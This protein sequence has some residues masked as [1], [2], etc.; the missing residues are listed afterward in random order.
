MSNVAFLF[1]GQGSQYVG[2]G[3]QLA[4]TW[5]SAIQIFEQADKALGI[6]LSS[7]C[8]EGPEDKL[9]LT[10][11]TQPAILATSIAALELLKQKGVKTQLV[12]GHSLG[13]YTA[14]VAAGALEFQEALRL[15][16]RRGRYM[17]EAVEP[18]KGSMAAILGLSRHQVEAV[19]REAR[20]TGIVDLANINGPAQIVIAGEKNAVEFAGQLALNQGAK[21]VIPL[22]VSVPSHCELM[23]PAAR[24]LASDLANIR[25]NKLEVPLVANYHA[26]PVTKSGEVREA[27]TQQLEHPVLWVDSMLEMKSRGVDTF[28]EIGPGKVL[29]G[30]HKRIDRGATML[31]VDDPRSFEVTLQ[32]LKIRN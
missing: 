11:N 16:K 5:E 28:I 21:K 20:A 31:N 22:P 10:E 4:E 1:P 30:L 27:L 18:G 2:M 14:L 13:E 12:A 32:C 9:N 7:L 19:C 6:N 25:F 3:R 24:R 26:K 23:R 8:W 15:V 17:Q 29:S